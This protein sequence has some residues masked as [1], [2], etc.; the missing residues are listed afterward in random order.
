MH[1]GHLVLSK[2]KKTYLKKK[3]EGEIEG[4]C[5]RAE[6]IFREVCGEVLK[7]SGGVKE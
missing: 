7:G 3:K 1:T 2:R 5:S 6:T 4:G